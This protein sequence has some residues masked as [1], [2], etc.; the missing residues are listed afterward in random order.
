MSDPKIQTVINQGIKK[1]SV[2]LTIIFTI[3]TAGIY[4]PC[5]FLTR[6][7]QINT[8]HSDEKIGKGIFIFGIV[9]F[10]IALFLALVSG[11]LEGM[12]EELGPAEFLAMAK[13]VDAIN[14]LLSL[15]VGIILLVQ[16]F[17]VRRIFR[18]H[19]NEYLGRNISFSGL[20][21]F[22][23]QIY[24]LQYKINRFKKQKKLIEN[25]DTEKIGNKEKNDQEKALFSSNHHQ[26]QD[27]TSNI[28]NM[29]VRGT[30]TQLQE[31]THHEPTVENKGTSNEKATLEILRNESVLTADEFA[32]KMAVVEASEKA[33]RF[34][35]LLC[36]T[37]EPL[38][39]KMSELKKA[40]LLDEQEYEQKKRA[41]IEKH[42]EELLSF[43][44]DDDRAMNMEFFDYRDI[45]DK[46]IK[47][48]IIETE[49][50][51]M[52]ELYRLQ[53]KQQELLENNQICPK[54]YAFRK[55][56]DKE[57][58]ACGQVFNLF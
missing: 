47:L 51:E 58:S 24:Y 53:E 37:T 56:F 30:T 49:E 11:F 50:Q 22:F 13:G 43:L 32:K 38:I 2:I 17:K 31:R 10:S 5:W 9:V 42:R 33:A 48:G 21:T 18:N 20:A 23:F 15:V 40:G 57:C 55:Q 54:C 12:G 39:N 16:C 46:K 52:D 27:L 1:T 6:R 3:I 19:F 8:L 41:V 45:L 26:K 36:S 25:N 28:Q 29:T 34:E 4:Y 7:D 44:E 35:K 14:S